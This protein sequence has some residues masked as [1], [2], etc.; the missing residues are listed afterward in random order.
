MGLESRFWLLPGNKITW[1]GMSKAPKSYIH[2]NNDFLYLIVIS[3]ATG[4][5]LFMLAIGIAAGNF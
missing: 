4:A 5:I 1:V 2:G 3:Y